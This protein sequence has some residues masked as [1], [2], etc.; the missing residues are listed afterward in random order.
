MCSFAPGKIYQASFV[1][2]NEISPKKSHLIS[3]LLSLILSSVRYVSGGLIYRKES[4][5]TTPL[6]AMKQTG[7]KIQ[8]FQYN[9][10]LLSRVLLTETVLVT[11]AALLL[12]ME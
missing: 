10:G 2:T 9:D 11:F 8:R 12:F 5:R 7:C 6:F 1:V 4:R 3:I